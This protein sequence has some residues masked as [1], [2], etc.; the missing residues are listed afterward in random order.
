MKYVVT[1]RERTFEVTVDGDRVRVDGRE[2]TTEFTGIPHTPLRQLVLDGASRMFALER[3]EEGWTVQAGGE[4]WSVHVEDER[5]RALRELT[6][7]QHGRG[8]VGLIRAPMPGL[9]LRVEVEEGQAVEAGAGV[10]VL[11]AMKME[12][13][14]KADADGVVSELRV[15]PGDQVEKGALLLVVQAAVG[16]GE[17]AQKGGA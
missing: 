1:L 17:G 9:V 10:V 12:L 4:R 16:R 14:M 6:G 11:E 2:H 15:A 13:P 8:A 7:Q 3:E 5:T